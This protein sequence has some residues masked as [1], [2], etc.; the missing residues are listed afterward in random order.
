[1]LICS[2]GEQ[3]LPG[4]SG[5]DGPPGP[6][7]RDPTSSSRAEPLSTVEYIELIS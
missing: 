7:V 1:M 5:Q 6:I 4:A 3:G 2:Q